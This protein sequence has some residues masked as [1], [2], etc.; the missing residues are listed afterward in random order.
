M[1]PDWDDRLPVR[2]DLGDAE[3]MALVEALDTLY[4]AYGGHGLRVEDVSDTPLLGDAIE[5]GNR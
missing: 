3:A 1:L 4:R 2:V 5:S